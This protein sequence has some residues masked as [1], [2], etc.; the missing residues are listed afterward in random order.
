MS[1][2]LTPPV[3]LA[4]NAVYIFGVSERYRSR[5]ER[6]G[7]VRLTEQQ[8]ASLAWTKQVYILWA[9]AI[10]FVSTGSALFFENKDLC[11]II[12][13]LGVVHAG[14]TTTLTKYPWADEYTFRMGRLQFRIAERC[15]WYSID[16]GR[17]ECRIPTG[18]FPAKWRLPTKW[19][20]KWHEFDVQVQS[21]VILMA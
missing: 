20:V 10:L 6:E 19:Q 16:G 11:H 21:G 1:D 14:A 13:V 12:T 5:I 17:S 7:K 3:H 2:C 18:P 8:A 15:Y 4:D 9:L